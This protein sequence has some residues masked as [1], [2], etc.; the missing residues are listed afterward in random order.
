ML[1]GLERRLGTTTGPLIVVGDEAAVG[2][3][4]HLDGD[5]EVVL[6][7]DHDAVVRRAASRGLDAR[8]TDVTD[9]GRLRDPAAEAD[10]AVV[11]TGRDRLNLLVAQLLR[12]VC[13]VGSV[14]VLVNDPDNR[15]VFDDLDVAV[16]DGGSVVASEVADAL[17]DDRR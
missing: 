10:A 4:A 16:I 12:T 9:A 15:D 6:V 17:F 7:S 14:A 2:L 13:S 3:A 8:Q 5:N 11:A 1:D